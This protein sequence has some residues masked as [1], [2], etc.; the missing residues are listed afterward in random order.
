MSFFTSFSPQASL[1]WVWRCYSA[2]PSTDA[3]KSAARAGSARPLQV[4]TT[5]C[6]FQLYEKIKCRTNRLTLY[7]PPI[8]C[9]WRRWSHVCPLRHP[10]GV[11]AKEQEASIGVPRS[12]SPPRP[13]FLSDT[14]W[15]ATS[16]QWMPPTEEDPGLHRTW[17]DSVFHRRFMLGAR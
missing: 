14:S 1:S 5:S 8:Q 2:F 17:M 15:T 3:A 10:G 11:T 12:I 13:G 7:L 9:L 6:I 16:M 4:S